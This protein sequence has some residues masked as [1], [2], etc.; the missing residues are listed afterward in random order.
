MPRNP[1]CDL[2]PL[3]SKC[4]TPCLW[5]KDYTFGGQPEV[6]FVFDNPTYEDDIQATAG[7]GALEKW[8]RKKLYDVGIKSFY[9]TYAVKC[10]IPGGGKPGAQHIKACVPYLIEEIEQIKPKV[11]VAVGDIAL[12]ALT[13]TTGITKKH[14]TLIPMKGNSDIL[15]FPI[16]SPAFVIRQPG[17]E[18]FLMGDLR[19]LSAL[20]REGDATPK[21]PSD[22]KWTFVDTWDKLEALKKHIDKGGHIECY[23]IEN[24]DER[25]KEDLEVFPKDKPAF[26]HQGKLMI[27][28]LTFRGV[29]RIFVI[30]FE[31]KDGP[32]TDQWRKRVFE[33]LTN[34]E[35]KDQPHTAF[36][37]KY[38][39]RWL[40]SRGIRPV[41]TSDPM[42][43]LSLLDENQPK[44]LK[45]QAKIR[46][47]AP[48][49]ERN[50]E[51][52]ED[53]PIKKLAFY[54]ALDMYYL[55]K[56]KHD[57][58]SELAKDQG[59]ARVYKHILVPTANALTRM[60][61]NGLYVHVDKLIDAKHRLT[62]DLNEY[63]ERLEDLSPIKGVNW[64]SPR[65]KAEV[66]FSTKGFGLDPFKLT[67]S[68]EP[69][70]DKES[71]AFL[72]MGA[73]KEARELIETLQ[74]YNKTRDLLKFVKSWEGYVKDS[75]EHFG[76]PRI[77][78][79]YNPTGT[80]TGRIS[81]EN[82]NLMQ[83]PRDS[84]LRGIFGAPEGRLLINLDGKQMELV[85]AAQVAQEPTMIRLIRSG[86]D[87]HVNTAMVITG[88]DEATLRAHS[89][90]KDLR[91][92][93]K[94]ANFGLLYGQQWEGFKRYA[95]VNYGVL[96]SDEEAQE[97]REKWFNEYSHIAS[98]HRRCE[99]VIK[100]TGEIRSLFG[101]IRHL[102]NVWSSDRSISSA[103]VREGINF[104][105]QSAA[106][107]Y[108]LLA[109]VHFDQNFAK[110][111]PSAALVG[112]V[113]D[114]I[115][116]E[117]DEDDLDK[118]ARFMKETVEV[119]VAE[120]IIPKKF[121]FRMSVPV[122]AEISY[123]R[124]WGEGQEWNP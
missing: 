102:P 13:G 18:T 71:L 38:D 24:S 53:Y 47:N 123:G 124:S 109:L 117:V 57:V 112:Y 12:K 80:R 59:L 121:G 32:N 51:Y 3:S 116:V 8:L 7:V 75:I 96:M 42:L 10:F 106:N 50:V 99:R 73:P 54:C 21:I 14:G 62:R 25:T 55:R 105:V 30:P 103:A 26:P 118:V 60:E 19:Y 70:T 48:D 56:M 87:L 77:F 1:K 82:P 95:Y 115:M 107:D 66:L 61:M 43:G 97:V 88:M 94:S 6:V 34:L 16:F 79:V 119:T 108:M 65:Q 28:G 36:N 35:E 27:I 29:D 85:W 58:H 122:T 23:D 78:A 20:V 17:N 22:F 69:S 83:V 39:N 46:Y 9:W 120:D 100:S 86:F 114:S 101:R 72:A 33:I 37:G 63:L 90:F 44:G 52:S 5:G 31:H 11:V 113:H 110:I 15:V 81:C 74:K 4:N 98:W 93:A 104:T 91:Q 92:K 111:A 84:N 68:G 2:C 76:V 45:Y 89:D 67:D 64:N 40:R 41:Q 49:Y